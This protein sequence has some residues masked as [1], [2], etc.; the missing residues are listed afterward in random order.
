MN[1]LYFICASFLLLFLP[2]EVFAQEKDDEPAFKKI[3]KVPLS[4]LDNDS[5]Y[6][7]E[8]VAVTKLSLIHI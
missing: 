8:F 4:L 3:I 7:M 6:T 5:E 2:S 1:K